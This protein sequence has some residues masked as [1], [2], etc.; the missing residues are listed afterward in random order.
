M[1]AINKN[2]DSLKSCQKCRTVWH[3]V[4]QL[5]RNYYAEDYDYYEDLNGSGSSADHYWY[6][7]TVGTHETIIIPDSTS[8]ILRLHIGILLGVVT[9]FDNVKVRK[10]GGNAGVMK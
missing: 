8:L 6:P 7:G 2:A 9:S 1:K 10:L 5:T 4:S 3:K